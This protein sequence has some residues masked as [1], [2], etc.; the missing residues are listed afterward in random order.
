MNVSKITSLISIPVWLQ[1][2]V[3]FPIDRRERDDALDEDPDTDEPE[4]LTD[5]T[6]SDDPDD[7]GPLLDSKQAPARR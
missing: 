6:E 1:H 4:S 7:D 5:E 3:V 2:G